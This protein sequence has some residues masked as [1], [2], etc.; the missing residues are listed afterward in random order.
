MQVTAAES[1]LGH[2]NKVTDHWSY[3]VHRLG[4]WLTAFVSGK[5]GQAVVPTITKDSDYT[6]YIQIIQTVPW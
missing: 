4:T 2:G 5:K 6:G 3:S 1:H